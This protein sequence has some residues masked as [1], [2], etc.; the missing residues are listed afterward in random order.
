M[1]D[2]SIIGIFTERKNVIA[3]KTDNNYNLSSPRTPGGGKAK[4]L[5]L[6]ESGADT[7][8]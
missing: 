2:F 4:Y 3:A 7:V 1:Y 6:L 8:K 5:L